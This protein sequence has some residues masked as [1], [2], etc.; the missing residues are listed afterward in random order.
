MAD[1]GRLAT[2][3]GEGTHKNNALQVFLRC[4]QQTIMRIDTS[5]RCV[6]DESIKDMLQT[7]KLW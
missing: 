6:T 4:I 3:E 2:H 5:S 7:S 1:L